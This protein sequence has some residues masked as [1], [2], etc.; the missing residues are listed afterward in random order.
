MN[1]S[2]IVINALPKPVCPRAQDNGFKFQINIK[3][4]QLVAQGCDYTTTKSEPTQ[5]IIESN[6]TNNKTITFSNSDVQFTLDL[7][8]LI[9]T[10]KYFLHNSQSINHNI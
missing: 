10:V 4:Y 3:L 5:P 1:L 8:K 6:Q 2:T 7:V 9:L